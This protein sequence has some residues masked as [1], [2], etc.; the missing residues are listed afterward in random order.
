LIR[1]APDL[2]GTVEHTTTPGFSRRLEEA[3]TTFVSPE[4]ITEDGGFIVHFFLEDHELLVVYEVFV[5]IKDNYLIKVD[6]QFVFSRVV[7][8]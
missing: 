3:G 6:K 5:H 1:F 4:L 2:H 7:D 8:A